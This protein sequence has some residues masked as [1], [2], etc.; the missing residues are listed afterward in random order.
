MR[1][2]RTWSAWL[3]APLIVGLPT[4]PAWG[5]TPD[6]A[7]DELVIRRGNRLTI[8]IWP[9]EDLGGE[10]QIEGSG[11]VFL[12]ILGEVPAAGLTLSQLT[13]DL[14]IRYADASRAPIVSVT[15]LF[16]VSVIGAV[17]RPGLYW[18]SPISR[19]WDVVSEAGGFRREADTKR[20]RILRGGRVFQLD[21]DQAL[22][23][24]D[25]RFNV[26]LRPDDRIVIPEARRISGQTVLLVLQS[27]LLLAN[28]FRL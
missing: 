15:L 28:L 3:V 26:S 4:S 25:E 27:V 10:F 22:R 23:V 11:S 19:M 6:Q 2:T 21:A 20:I 8:R 13:Q 9:D 5:Q 16:P 17:V 24:G 14:R 7:V 18:A 1:R 12:P